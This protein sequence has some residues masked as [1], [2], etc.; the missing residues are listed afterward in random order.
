[1]VREGLINFLIFNGWSWGGVV[2]DYC[3]VWVEIYV[4]KDLDIVD[5]SIGVE[6]FNLIFGMEG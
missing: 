6:V 1:M 4:G 3:F 2:S 5:L